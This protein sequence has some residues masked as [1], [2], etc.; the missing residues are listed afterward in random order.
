MK[1]VLGIGSNAH[2]TKPILFKLV[3]KNPNPATEGRFYPGVKG[4][5]NKDSIFDPE[6]NVTKAIRYSINEESIY[7]DEQ[8]QNVELTDIIFTNGSLRVYEDN[9]TLLEYLR[10]CNYNADNPNRIR[11]GKVAMFYEYNPE[12]SAKEA[13]E[14]ES[15]SIDAAYKAK[16]MDFTE[17]V[18]IARA[19]KVNTDRSASEV[20]HDMV[21]FAKRSPNEFMNALDSPNMKRKVEVIELQELGLVKFDKRSAYVS[22]PGNDWRHVHSAQVGNNAIESFVTWT[23]NTKEGE[24]EF[25]DLMKKRKLMLD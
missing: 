13:M 22:S 2:I 15:L 16:N 19:L 12:A 21:Q 18:G 20:R 14:H 10:K 3:K 23:L 4:I 7:R 8:P 9:P 25:K 24:I 5:P 6:K 17:L 1:D 11:K